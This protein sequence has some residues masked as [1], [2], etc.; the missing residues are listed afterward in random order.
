MC[1]SPSAR[2]WAS[3]RA[4]RRSRHPPETALIHVDVD[5][6][7]IGRHYPVA[8]YAGRAR[9]ACAALAERLAA[10]AAPL[11][12]RGGGKRGRAQA[13]APRRRSRRK[14][15]A[16]LR[17]PQAPARLRGAAEGAAARH[18]RH[19]GR[20][21]APAY[22]YDRLASRSPAPSS[23]RWTSAASASPS[24]WRWEPSS[25]T[26]GAGA[27]HPRRR[28][29]LMNVQELETAVRHRINVV[30]LVMNTTAGARE[31]LSAGVLRRALYRLRHREPA[32]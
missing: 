30:T 21:R 5:A 9:L 29:Y 12:A 16:S 14:K 20:R 19:P 1:C 26:R 27:G 2:G 25:P 28:G 31:G 23:P 8:S 32:L 11:T 13:E 6:R 22:G 15:A 18:H 4:L 3:S 10:T 7:E 24:R 17:A